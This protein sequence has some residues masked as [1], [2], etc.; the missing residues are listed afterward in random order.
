MKTEALQEDRVYKRLQSVQTD[1]SSEDFEPSVIRYLTVMCTF[2]KEVFLL[3][4]G[5]GAII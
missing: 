2:I 4:D 3:Q 1:G 5:N